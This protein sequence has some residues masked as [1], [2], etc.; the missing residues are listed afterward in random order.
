MNMNDIPEYFVVTCEGTTGSSGLTYG[1]VLND[2][3]HSLGGVSVSFA[4][5]GYNPVEGENLGIRKKRGRLM[6]TLIDRPFE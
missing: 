6:K 3:S 2:A 5:Q 1:R 4:V